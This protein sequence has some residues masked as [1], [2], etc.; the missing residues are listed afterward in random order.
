MSSI[1]THRPLPAEI[2]EIQ[3][4]M[5]KHAKGYGLDFFKTI[6]EMVDYEVHDGRLHGIPGSLSALAIRSPV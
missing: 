5:E 4:E 3:K 6:F 2:A 1:S